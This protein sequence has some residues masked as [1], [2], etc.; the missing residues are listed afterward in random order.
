VTYW[1]SNADPV[2]SARSRSLWPSRWGAKGNTCISEEME[3]AGIAW[4]GSGEGWLVTGDN[5]TDIRVMQCE[6]K[7][8]TSGGGGY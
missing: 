7:V 5:G 3:N 8:D 6:K 4:P 2:P 1:D